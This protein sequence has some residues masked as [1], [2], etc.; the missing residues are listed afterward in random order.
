MLNAITGF[1]SQGVASVAQSVG[2]AVD[3]NLTTDEERLKAANIKA[4]IQSSVALKELD[5]QIAEAQ[6]PSVFVAGARPFQLWASTGI[7][8]FLLVGVPLLNW[9][10]GIVGAVTG[11]DLPEIPLEAM[12]GAAG[13]AG[14]GAFQYRERRKEKKS[15][16]ARVNLRPS[17]TIEGFRQ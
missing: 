8:I 5:R 2:E 4:E 10:T 16:T 11:V 13:S 9:L 17:Y 14:L 15:G 3:R 1:M 12:M 6:H 7:T